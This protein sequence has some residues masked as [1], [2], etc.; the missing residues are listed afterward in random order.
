VLE[1]VVGHVRQLV[2][3][4]E[5]ALRDQL[6]VRLA[7]V[8]V[9]ELYVDHLPARRDSLLDCRERVAEPRR[10]V[11]PAAEGAELQPPARLSKAE[12]V[13]RRLGND[14]PI[15]VDALDEP[16]AASK[17]DDVAR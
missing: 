15:G 5:V 3:L 6:E 11:A 8:V 7:L 1:L 14:T 13:A 12:A 10:V 9:R 16:V 2:E 17:P 4:E